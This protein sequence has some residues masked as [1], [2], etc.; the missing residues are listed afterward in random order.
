MA[1]FL[2]FEFYQTFLRDVAW[3]FSLSARQVCGFFER[4]QESSSTTVLASATATALATG[5]VV[6]LSLS[7]SAALH[8]LLSGLV[9]I[10][11]ELWAVEGI[12]HDFLCPITLERMSDP[13]VAADGHTYERSAIEEWIASGHTTSP[14][15]TSNNRAL[16]SK[17]LVPSLGLKARLDQWVEGVDLTTF[18]EFYLLD[19]IF[20][21]LYR[22]SLTKELLADVVQ[23][24]AGRVLHKASAGAGDSKTRQSV[25]ASLLPCGNAI[26]GVLKELFLLQ[27]ASQEQE[28]GG[29]EYTLH[30]SELSVTIDTCLEQELC[31]AMSEKQYIDTPISVAY[32]NVRQEHFLAVASSSSSSVSTPPSPL[33]SFPVDEAVLR[34]GVDY[35]G[36]A[37]AGG[38]GGTIILGR[39]GK[40][41]M[42]DDRSGGSAV[43]TC[44]Q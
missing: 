27:A 1:R 2:H 11:T 21:P 28:G 13:V 15:D 31:A 8:Q 38:G 24:L 42:P 7:S 40:H 23:I 26:A 41:A 9:D 33:I 4:F 29:G 20:H 37:G 44:G 10:G 3:P 25:T 39:S 18:L 32:V 30:L 16:V 19:V 36:A 43:Y 12:P 14:F 5:S 6:P 17:L 22:S 35:S 34:Q